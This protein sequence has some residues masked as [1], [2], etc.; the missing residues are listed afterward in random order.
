MSFTHWLEGLTK[1]LQDD[2]IVQEKA[3]HNRDTITG[4]CTSERFKASVRRS[5]YGGGWVADCFRCG[6]ESPVDCKAS[7]FDAELHACVICKA[8]KIIGN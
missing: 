7:D 1:Q 6:L 2:P 3:Y 8:A 4:D 5:R